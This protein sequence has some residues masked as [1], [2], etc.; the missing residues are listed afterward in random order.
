M[1]LTRRLYNLESEPDSVVSEGVQDLMQMWRSAVESIDGEVQTALTEEANAKGIA[2][3]GAF[4]VQVDDVGAVPSEAEGRPG[5][6]A[7]SFPHTAQRFVYIF[8]GRMLHALK[9][10]DEWQIIP[11]LKGRGG[12]GKST[13]ASQLPIKRNFVGGCHGC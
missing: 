8:M 2:L 10:H 5:N 13:V 4:G 11:F 12:S 3:P 7:S 6:R 9:L 1:E